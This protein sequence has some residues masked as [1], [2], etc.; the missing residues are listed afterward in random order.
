M[1]YSKFV[2]RIILIKERFEMKTR[3]L[4]IFAVFVLAGC[5]S[6]PPVPTPKQNTLLVG[7]I[8]VNWSV[9]GSLGPDQRP[10]G[11]DLEINSGIAI[12]FHNNQTGKEISVTTQKHGWLLT[13]KLNGGNYTIQTFQMERDLGGITHRMTL[14]GPIYITI[15]EGLVNN[16]GVIQIDRKTSYE[17]R[18]V[19]YDVVKLDFQM[20]FPDSQWNSYEWKNTELF[21]SKNQAKALA[22][23][24]ANL[25]VNDSPHTVHLPV[26]TDTDF[27]A[28]RETLNASDRY[29]Y[30]TLSNRVLRT[31]EGKLIKIIPQKA[32]YGTEAPYGC[33]RLVG[34][35]IPNSVSVIG[36]D[37]FRNCTSLKRVEISNK[38]TRIGQYTFSG[39]SSLE[40]V[41]IPSRVRYID[42]YAFSGCSNLTSVT[43]QGRIVPA[44][45]SSSDTFPGDLR[46]KYLE[47]GKGTYKL[48]RT[49]NTWTKQ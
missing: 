9:S 28:L 48:D 33:D 2:M 15:E 37:A 40:S 32:F 27:K 39:C 30:L 17:F 41:T 13:S 4:V 16:I 6:V 42:Q 20:E 18:W 47:G 3:A 46:A 8:L 14:G 35:T 44:F 36:E 22:A 25:P 34:I 29:V 12:I 7:K 21:D 45:F 38:V 31:N 24:L 19:D 26:F 11:E 1:Q 5:V 49:S 23:W 10:G 43:F